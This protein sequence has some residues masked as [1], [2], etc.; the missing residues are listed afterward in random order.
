MNATLF[1]INLSS[2]KGTVKHPVSSA[3]LTSLGLEDD[4]HAGAWHRQVSLLSREEVEVFEA[5]VGRPVA[6]GEFGENFTTR[7]VDIDGLGLL[8]RLRIGD[9][10]LEITQ[11][12]KTCHGSSCAI[13]QAAGDCIMPRKGVFARVVRGGDI[14]AGQAVTVEHRPLRIAVVTLSDRASAGE[15]EDRSGPAIAEKLSAHFEQTRWHL[16]L[17][18]RVIPDEAAALEAILTEYRDEGFDAVF[19]TGGTGLGPRDITPD[20]VL[21]LAERQIPGIMEAIRVKYGQTHPSALLSRS[22]AATLG[23]TAV[24]ALPGSVKAAREYTEEILKTL[25]HLIQMIHG[26]GH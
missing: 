2:E 21:G 25:E 12:G 5:K 6:P 7:G 14:H 17:S 16:E 24:Y 3:R 20:V 8:D 15:Y 11:L 23:R 26:M 4:A 22:V 19:A 10:V 9:S 18:R 1:S 13:Y